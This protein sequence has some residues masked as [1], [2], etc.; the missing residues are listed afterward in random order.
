[1]SPQLTKNI[2]LSEAPGGKPVLRAYKD[3]KGIWTI[4]FGRNL[5]VM[6]ITE[7]Q[8]EAYLTEDILAAARLAEKLPSWPFMDT[9]ARQDAFIEL[10]YNMGPA[11]FDGVGTD[12]FKNTMAA[13]ARRDWLAVKAGLLNSKWAGDVKEARATRIANQMATGLYP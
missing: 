13:M 8:A 7:S 4:G 2:K 5:Q 6:T 10:I 1:M 9:P 11:H 12:D 3:T